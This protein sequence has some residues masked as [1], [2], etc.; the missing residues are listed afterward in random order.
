[1]EKSDF[2]SIMESLFDGMETFITTK[3]VVGEEKQYGDTTIVPLVNI[4]FGVGAGSFQKTEK[5]SGCGGL[6]GKITPSAVLVIKGDDVRIIRVNSTSNME[7]LLDMVPGVVSKIK[8]KNK[9]R[10]MTED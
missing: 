7:K 2:K 8:N 4:S 3:T 1:M 10:S 5:G 9:K 6:G